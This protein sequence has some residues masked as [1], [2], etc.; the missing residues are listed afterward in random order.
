[1]EEQTQSIPAAKLSFPSSHILEPV[2]RIHEGVAVGVDGYHPG[3][4]M[5]LRGEGREILAN[6]DG[7][8]A[9]YALEGFILYELLVGL[10]VVLQEVLHHFAQ[11]LVE[12]HTD[13]LVRLIGRHFRGYVVAYTL[14]DPVRFG[15]K[16]AELIVELPKYVAQVIE[17]SFCLVAACLQ[18]GVSPRFFDLHPQ[19]PSQILLP[20]TQDI[21]A[22][23]VIRFVLLY[24]II[25][26]TNYIDRY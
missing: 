12:A 6:G 26:V 13:A 24:I 8:P 4:G 23:A 11:G 10:R 5:V 3:V 9:D 21:Q 22:I 2:P 16:G 14:G 15:E 1:M 7:L 18:S 17:F 20:S 25:Q 19:Y